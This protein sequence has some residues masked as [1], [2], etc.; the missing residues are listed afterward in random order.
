LLEN[1][2]VKV[3]KVF[4]KE[5]GKSEECRIAREISGRGVAVK[6]FGC[7]DCKCESHLFRLKHYQFLREFMHE[8]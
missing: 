1:E 8:T 4:Q 7:S 2:A 5:A 3:L 6:G